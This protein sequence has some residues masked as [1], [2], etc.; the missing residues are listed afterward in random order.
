VTFQDIEVCTGYNPPNPTKTVL[1]RP[2]SAKKAFGPDGRALR[3]E[4]GSPSGASC[5]AS[6]LSDDP[7]PMVES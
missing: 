2:T 6:L 3:L 5:P 4:A 7:S 1:V